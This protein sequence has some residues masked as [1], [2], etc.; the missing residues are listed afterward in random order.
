MVAIPG[1]D[2]WP[3]MSPCEFRRYRLAEDGCPEIAQP[4]D[5]PGIRGGN[6]TGIDG[7]PVRGRHVGGGDD[8]L[9]S[10]R[11][12]GERAWPPRGIYGQIL[13]RLQG[14]LEGLCLLQAASR[15]FI[16]HWL[17]ISKPT[18]KFQDCCI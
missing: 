17:V 4:L 5:H 10:H 15:V 1:V 2:R 14:G 11:N 18:Q 3:R 12:A 13:E 8:V 7:R 6:L 16:R 9:D